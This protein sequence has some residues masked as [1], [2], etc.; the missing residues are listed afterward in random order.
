MSSPV[1]KSKKRKAN[2]SNPLNDEK[3]GKKLHSTLPLKDYVVPSTQDEVGKFRFRSETDI[4]KVYEVK[5]LNN[6]KLS[7]NC[8]QKWGEA[9]RGHCKH[10]SSVLKEMIIQYSG[11][12]G[13]RG[14]QTEINNMLDSLKI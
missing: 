12:V 6:G 13:L 14:K 3:V 8:G 9:S 11:S 5:I 10:V 1:S 4:T 7:C 2:V